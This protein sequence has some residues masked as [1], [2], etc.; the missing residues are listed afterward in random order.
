MIGKPMIRAVILVL[1]LT[2]AALRTRRVELSVCVTNFATRHPA[3]T[4]GAAASGVSDS[5][6]G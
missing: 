4:A 3:I 2:L 6:E 1:A 5:A